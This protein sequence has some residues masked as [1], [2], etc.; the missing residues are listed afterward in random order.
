[1]KTILDAAYMILVK[2]GLPTKYWLKAIYT[3]I[4]FQNLILS[5]YCPDTVL[6]EI[7]FGKWQS[8]SYL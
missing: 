7:W 3:T 4:Y 1:M 5:C 6:A 2:L 8:V